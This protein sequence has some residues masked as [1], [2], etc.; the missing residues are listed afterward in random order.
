MIFIFARRAAKGLVMDYIVDFGLS[1]ADNFIG[2]G[3][4]GL[5]LGDFL[6]AGIIFNSERKVS[7]SFVALL[8]AWEATNFFPFSLIPIFGEV[9]EFIC[10]LIPSVT[11]S[12][13][14][15]SKFGAAERTEKKI[16][17]ETALALQEN[18]DVPKLKERLANIHSLIEHSNPVKAL[19]IAN[20][21][22]PKIASLLT[23][24][25]TQIIAETQQYVQAV[26]QAQGPP[27]LI[28]ALEEGLH[29]TEQLIGMAQSEIDEK[30]FD[31]AIEHSKQA[32][33]LIQ[34][35]IMNYN[36]ALTH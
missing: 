7:N 18:L 35:V 1:M 19:N 29:Q 16:Q 9:L 26:Q 8:L 11:I 5:D 21:T 25:V 20:Q 23:D 24:H 34:D 15:F 36:S 17:H 22:E 28:H 2:V 3:L 10:G 13:L 4:V 12:R 30:D 31:A 32:Y 33:E 27:E 14:L 6:A